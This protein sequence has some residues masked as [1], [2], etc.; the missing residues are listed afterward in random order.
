MHLEECFALIAAD[1]SVPFRTSIQYTRSYD[2]PSV[3]GA[4]DRDFRIHGAP[5]VLREDRAK[6]HTAEPVASV[7]REHG[8]LVLQGPP[9]YPQYYGQLERQNAEHRAWWHRRL[10]TS[11]P[12]QP[13]LDAMKTAF[14][15]RWLRPTL[16]W[17]NAAQCW[18]ERPSLDED[19]DALRDEVERRAARLRAANV[20]DDLAMRLAIEQ[21]LT[22]RGFLKITPGRLLLCD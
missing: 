7:L 8:V 16:G 5:L 20:S 15:E 19:R 9:H 18:S 4:L 3:A 6:C 13:Q 22:K 12:P 2:A 1:W 11:L 21:A 17:R 14:N 10:P